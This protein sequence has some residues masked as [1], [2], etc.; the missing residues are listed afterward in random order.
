MTQS[1]EN[2]QPPTAGDPQPD[3]LATKESFADLGVS[4]EIIESLTELG[5]T[6]PFPI[7]ELAIPIALTGA[8][9]IGQARTGTGKT[10]AFGIPLL[11]RIL[12]AGDDDFAE[13]ETYGKPQA[14]VLTPTRELAIQVA[15]DIASAAKHRP[16]RV[17]TIYGGVGYD[18]QLDVLNTGVDIVVGT[19]GRL[20]DLARRRSLDLSHVMRLVLDEADEMLNMGFLPDVEALVNMTRSDRQSLLFSAT[21]P[22]PIVALAKSYMQQPVHVRAEGHDA[23]MT[24][25]DTTQFVYQTHDLDKTEILG[26]LLQAATIGKM[27][28]FTHTKRAASRVSEDLTERGFETA[29][30]HGDMSQTARETSLRKFRKG[31]VKVLVCTDV[32]ARGIDVTGVTHVVNYECPDDA[33]TYVHR[34]GRTGRAGAIGVAVT[35]VDWRDLTKWKVINRALSLDFA[36]PTEAYSTSAQ[37][38][39]NLGIPKDVK[40]RIAPPTPREPKNRPENRTANQRHSHTQ[41]A[42]IT[43]ERSREVAKHKERQEPRSLPAVAD[44]ERPQRERQR[45]RTRGGQSLGNAE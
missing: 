27:M 32:A 38:L 34:I 36:D 13:L 26:K 21:M 5:I 29:T 22:S 24:V 28:V 39:D 14:L 6:H 3:W 35:F 19:P 8:D 40:G 9:L 10:L 41:R 16:V 25:P 37:L 12:L 1:T 4:P 44:T 33:E 17:L 7:Q 45:R 2:T 20:L 31:Q 42:A 23:Q 11:Q 43:G 15:K 30:I 18:D